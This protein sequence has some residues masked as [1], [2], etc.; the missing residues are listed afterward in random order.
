MSALLYSI[1]GIVLLIWITGGIHKVSEGYIGLYWRGGALIEG[2]TEPG[3]HLMVP[4]VTTM[5][6]VQVS[7][8]TD[9]VEDIPVIYLL[10][11]F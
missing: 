7:V 2:Y 5:A 4:F 11:K 9:L 8:E 1:I 3:F 10:F 6:E